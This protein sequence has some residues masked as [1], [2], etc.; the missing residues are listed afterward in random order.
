MNGCGS[1]E[2]SCWSATP[3][4]TNP[5]NLNDVLTWGSGL[6]RTDGCVDGNSAQAAEPREGGGALGDLSIKLGFGRSLGP[7]CVIQTAVAHHMRQPFFTQIA[8]DL[9]RATRSLIFPQNIGADLS[10]WAGLLQ[11]QLNDARAVDPS[12]SPEAL[13]YC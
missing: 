8:S 7:L 13:V 11:L 9:Q 5:N 10:W 1:G 3:R 12:L 6:G 4:S 2:A